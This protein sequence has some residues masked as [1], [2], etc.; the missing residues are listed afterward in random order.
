MSGASATVVFV[1]SALTGVLGT[2][3]AGIAY[4]GARRNDSET[5]RALSVGIL[6]VTL[7]PFIV[8]YGLSPLASL[9]DAETLLGV[10]L[11]YNVGLLAFLYSLEL[12]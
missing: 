11:A 4:R 7:C 10:F 3:V 1:A 12:T 6:C 5:M 2:F 8:T 9:S